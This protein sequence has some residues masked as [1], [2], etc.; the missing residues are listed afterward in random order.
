MY[1]VEGKP[2]KGGGSVAISQDVEL[3]GWLL[4]GYSG[5]QEGVKGDS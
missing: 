2:K 3:V 1:E 5:R 4:A